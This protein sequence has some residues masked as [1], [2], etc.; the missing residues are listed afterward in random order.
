[1]RQRP[2]RAAAAISASDFRIQRKPGDFRAAYGVAAL[3]PREQN[4]SRTASAVRVARKRVTLPRGG[5]Q[6]LT[7]ARWSPT[8][9]LTNLHTAMDRLFSDL[10]GEA[11]HSP[12]TAAIGRPGAP[13]FQLPVDVEEVDNG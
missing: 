13:T 5:E 6:V 8:S 10:F 7:L 1:M 9:E 3:Q 4:R 11:S 2:A 12:L